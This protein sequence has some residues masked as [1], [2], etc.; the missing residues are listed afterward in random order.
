M[1]STGFIVDMDNFGNGG[2]QLRLRCSPYSA[3]LHPFLASV[4]SGVATARNPRS[5]QGVTR[6]NRLQTTHR[7]SRRATYVR[8]TMASARKPSGILRGDWMAGG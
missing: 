8:G 3:V 6:V 2:R 1:A 5:R 4:V 7:Y